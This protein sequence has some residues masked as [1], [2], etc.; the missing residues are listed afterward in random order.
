MSAKI[1]I[2]V[3]NPGQLLNR[4]Y[5]FT[6]ASPSAAAAAVNP[7]AAAGPL[8]AFNEKNT[9]NVALRYGNIKGIN[10]ALRIAFDITR[11]SSGISTA[12]V[13]LYNLSIASRNA[14]N[15]GYTVQ[16]QAGYPG[17]IDTILFGSVF[18]P[19]SDRKITRPE[20][21]RKASDIITT[22]N[23]MDGI[24]S[25]TM[26]TF[27]KNYQGPVSFTQVI[28]DVAKAMGLSAGISMGI[29][30]DTFNKGFI[31]HGP[32]RNI[33]DKL[34][35][36]KGLQWNVQNGSL[37]IYPNKG[38]INV[39]AQ[40]VSSNTGMIGVPSN[41]A[42]YTQVTCLL[43]PKLTPGAYVLLQSENKSLNGA[44]KIQQAHY[45]GDTHGNKWQV[46]L[47]MTPIKVV[48]YPVGFGDNF[49]GATIPA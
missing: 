12:T 13:Q 26:S 29:P 42:L 38:V 48:S 40:L 27:D 17:L 44:Y 21:V 30:Q 46:S 6:M 45:E 22:I 5:A 3:Q 37:N 31:A 49:A 14:L 18:L 24:Y 41:N 8:A 36:P 7:I 9:G 23:V 35:E 47:D 43:N 19:N 4:M 34:C 11:V 28:S 16:L 10:A 20:S 1:N 15:V 32:I 33:L 39:E 25:I 2:A